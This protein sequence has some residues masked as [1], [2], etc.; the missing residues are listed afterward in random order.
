MES[1]KKPD[2]SD[3]EIQSDFKFNLLDALLELNSLE[4]DYDDDPD[5]QPK[6]IKA[7]RYEDFLGENI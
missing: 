5:G 1:P 7:S 4:T 2:S 6:I 3:S